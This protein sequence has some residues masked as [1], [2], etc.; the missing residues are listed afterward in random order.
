[1][2]KRL[3]TKKIQTGVFDV[4]W[5]GQKTDFE[6]TNGSLGLTGADT[7]NVYLIHHLPSGK[8]TTIGPLNSCKAILA[9]KM[10]KKG[11]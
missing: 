11:K 10:A 8:F 3:T 7:T 4:Y 1:M 9:L 6:I 5:D 2:D